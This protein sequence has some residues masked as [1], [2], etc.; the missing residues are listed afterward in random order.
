[1]NKLN[2]G[3]YDRGA[4]FISNFSCRDWLCAEY[5]HTQIQALGRMADWLE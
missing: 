5:G 4:G 1:M 3:S 2:M